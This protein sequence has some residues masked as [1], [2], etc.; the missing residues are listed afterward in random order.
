MYRHC[1]RLE[2]DGDGICTDLHGDNAMVMRALT[3]PR[4]RRWL[5]L[6]W[7]K[8]RGTPRHAWWRVEMRLIPLRCWLAFQ[9]S[10]FWN[11]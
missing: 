1:Y 5:W 3:G 10:V 8:H 11:K 4:W 9:W 2:A 6:Q 7:I